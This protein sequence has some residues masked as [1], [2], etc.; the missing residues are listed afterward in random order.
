VQILAKFIALAKSDD[1]IGIY[2]PSQ[3]LVANGV[4]ASSISDGDLSEFWYPA[5]KKLH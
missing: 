1:L 2:T 3:T 4:L 5:A